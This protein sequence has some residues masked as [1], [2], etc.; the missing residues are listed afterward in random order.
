MYIFRSSLLL[1]AMYILSACTPIDHSFISNPEQ[2]RELE[3][4]VDDAI[5]PNLKN[6]VSNEN[7]S[8]GVIFDFRIPVSLRHSL[9]SFVTASADDCGVIGRYELVGE[10]VTA[11]TVT[12]VV[13][14]RGGTPFAAIDVN[15]ASRH[16]Y[17]EFTIRNGRTSSFLNIKS[18]D[19]PLKDIGGVLVQI[20]NDRD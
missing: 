17:R 12:Q 13:L 20:R 5:L 19:T 4:W 3:A 7:Q 2:C 16:P 1:F 9:P 14:S 6:V 15:G 8:I 10:A 11:F 18:R